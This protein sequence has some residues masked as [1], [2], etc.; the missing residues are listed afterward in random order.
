MTQ[1][2]TDES[3]RTY[4]CSLYFRTRICN[5]GSSV[6]GTLRLLIPWDTAHLSRPKTQVQTGVAV[7]HSRYTRTQQCGWPGTNLGSPL[8]CCVTLGRFLNP[9][10][11]WHPDLK[12]SNNN[13]AYFIGSL[14]RLN[15]LLETNANRTMPAPSKQSTSIRYHC[16]SWVSHSRS[17]HFRSSLTAFLKHK[18]DT[19]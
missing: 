2:L 3:R 12:T 1:Y 13:S 16:E 17:F 11:P 15:S 9:S 7:R 6:L 19:L 4:E 10:E 5:R 18:P 8:I 14:W